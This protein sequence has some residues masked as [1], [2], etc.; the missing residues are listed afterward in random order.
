[1]RARLRGPGGASTIFLAE[2][3]TVGDLISQITEKTLISSFDIKYGYP[4]RPLVLEECGNSTLLTQLDV[5][6]DGEQLT[7]SPKDEPVPNRNAVGAAVKQ[8]T[9]S[10]DR[11]SNTT[12]QERQAQEPFSFADVPGVQSKASKRPSAVSLQRKAMEG[13]VPELPLP[14]RGATLGRSNHIPLPLH[15]H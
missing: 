9:S 6:L 12:Q 15:R 1:M 13:D 10:D 8:E 4:P 2:D 3:A 7:I 5:R 11:G 14:E